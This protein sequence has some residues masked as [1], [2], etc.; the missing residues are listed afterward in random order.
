MNSRSFEA[1]LASRG[2]VGILDGG[3]GS[4][5]AERGWSLPELPEEMNLKA[6]EIV[7]SIHK[8]YVEAGASI[9][10]TNTFGGSSKKMALRGLAGRTMEINRSAA[11]TARRAS[12]G[13]A[14]VAGSVGPLGELLHPFGV[15]T[16]EEAR[17]AFRPQIEGLAAGG[18]DFILIETMI[19]LSEATAAVLAAKDAAPDLAFAVSFT[20][21]NRGRTV[22]G[23]PPE[24]AG[25]WARS[26]GACAVGANCG[27]GPDAYLSVTEALSGCSGLPVFA[28]P[29]AGIPGR[30]DFW[31]PELFSE[32]AIRLAAA[33]ASVIGG[34]CGTTPEHIRSLSTALD[35]FELPRPSRPEG[36]FLSSR[37]RVVTAGPGR[38]L[39]IVGERI[40]MSRKS[41][42]RDEVAAGRWEAVRNEASQQAA[43]GAGA[44]DIN[45]GLPGIDQASAVREAA[46][47]VQQATDLPLSLDSDSLEVIEAGLGSSAGIT[48]INS[49]TAKEAHLERG[50]RLASRY[51]ACLTVLLMD[52]DGIPETA[53][54]RIRILE[55][56]LS[57]AEQHSFPVGSLFIDALTLAAGAVEDGPAATIETIREIARRGARSILGISNVSHG[58]P[59]RPL[60]NRTFLAMAMSAGLDAVIADPL[61]AALMETVSASESLVGR[62]PGIRRYI[63]MAEKLRSG[64]AGQTAPVKQEETPK[65]PMDRLKALIVS[66]DT[67][68]AMRTAGEMAHAQDFSP[69]KLIQEGVVPALERV[70]LLFD[71]GEF[72]LPQL[73]SAAQAA[74]TVCDHARGMMDADMAGFSS[75]RV[76]LATVEGDLH[77]LGKNVVGTILGSHGFEVVDLGRSVPLAD[78]MKAVRSKSPDVVALSALM[79]TTMP[80]MGRV[81]QAL[82]EEGLDVPVIVGG[83]CVT[84]GFADSIGAA[85]Y[86][87]DAVSAVGVVARIIVARKEAR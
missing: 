26:I 29:N 48:L 16:F 27:A 47:F 59:C 11:E 56:V 2:R 82:E 3:M 45:M 69:M 58:L 42:L 83:A 18:V 37:S 25:H 31:D 53:R 68:G 79:T 76:L 35:G 1:W 41:P 9:I 52:E 23:T 55:R 12:S 54:D 87:S 43:A 14:L 24:V 13:K 15:L 5:L 4:L 7:E 28:Y 67:G 62:D 75:G 66:G 22:T 8:A 84:Q 61:D 81:V 6:P 65:D 46:R 38:P 20:F 72:F 49:V 64:T 32:A 74:Q 44:I 80:E 51:G 85:G 39:L 17:D 77:D 70:G 78:I 19:D 33:G 50:L 40:N 73:L 63:A 60:L 30:E 10:E 21:D 36:T 34:C 71:G 57:A 86:A